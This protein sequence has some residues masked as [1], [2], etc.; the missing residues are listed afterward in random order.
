[1]LCA[2]NKNINNTNITTRTKLLD[3]YLLVRECETN[4]LT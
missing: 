3:S 2:T 1:M 4:E